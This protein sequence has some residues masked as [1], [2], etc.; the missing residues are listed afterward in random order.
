MGPDAGSV[1]LRR[2]LAVTAGL[3]AAVLLAPAAAPADAADPSSGTVTDTSTSITWTG[4]PVRRAPTPPAPPVTRPATPATSCDDYTLHVSTPPG[5]GGGHQLAISVALGAT[6]PPTSTSTCSTRPGRSS[7]PP[8]RAPTPS[9]CSLPPDTGD[10]TVRVVPYAPLGESI[11]GKAELTTTPAN[12]APAELRPRPTYPTYAAPESLADAHDAGE[13]SIG[14]NPTTG[15]VMYQ[16]YTVDLQGR[17]RRRDH[18]R[19]PG[20]DRSASATNGC[21]LGSTTSLDPILFTDRRP[22]GR[23]SRS[24]PARPPH[25]LHRRRRRRPGHPTRARA[26]TPASTTRR[27][28]GGP[29]ADSGAARPLTAATRTPS[30]TARRTSPTRSARVSLDGGRTFGP[31]VPIYNLTA[32]RRPA[33]PRQGRAATAPPTCRTRAAAPGRAVAVSDRQRPDLD[34]PRRCPAAPPATPTRRSASA[35][36]APSTSAT[37]TPTATP[38]SRSRTTSGQTWSDDQD[39]GAQLGIQ[40]VVFPAVVAG[41]DDRAAFAFLGTTTGGNY[42]DAADLPRRLAP[43]RRAPP[44]DG[45]ADLGDRRRDARPTRCS[46]ARSA[47]AAPPAATTATCSTS[48]TSPSTARAACWSATPTAASAPAPHGRGAELRRARHDRPPDRRAAPVRRVRRPARP[49]RGSRPRRRGTAS[50]ATFSAVVT[51]SGGCAGE[52]GDGRASAAARRRTRTSQPITLA[53]GASADGDRDEHQLPRGTQTLTAVVDPANTVAESDEGNNRAT[54]H[55]GHV[56]AAGAE[57]VDHATA[58]RPT[59]LACWLPSPSPRSPPAAAA[60]DGGAGVGSPAGSPCPRTATPAEQGCRAAPAPRRPWTVPPTRRRWTCRRTSRRR[61]R[62]AASSSPS[63]SGTTAGPSSP[64]WCRRA[65]PDVLARP[66]GGLPRP[67]A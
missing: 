41:D 56:N 19:P 37:R 33:R 61:C 1:Q 34:G 59:P 3:A 30:T 28:G 54:R 27:I 38:A 43:L 12:P 29:F 49:D 40:N 6:P 13:P 66:A 55:G 47:P 2:R 16:A 67:P 25:L 53:P 8:R 9:R 4:G 63:S 20:P 24:W 26:S 51:N 36:T 65:E 57:D 45:G 58:S 46:A 32:V 7:A 14:V 44:I 5:Y 17:L 64:P 52:R 22:A 35:R 42:Q 10:Y 31:A 62:T 48:W 50:T 11:T 23:S 39:V 21:P 18:A 15:A 60:G